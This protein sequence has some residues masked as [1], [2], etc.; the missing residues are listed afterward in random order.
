[1]TVLKTFYPFNKNRAF[2]QIM[3]NRSSQSQDEVSGTTSDNDDNGSEDLGKTVVDPCTDSEHIECCSN[4]KHSLNEPVK[5]TDKLFTELYPT[6]G[7]NFISHEAKLLLIEQANTT[8]S[9]QDSQDDQSNQEYQRLEDDNYFCVEFNGKMYEAKVLQTGKDD[10]IYWKRFQY[11]DGSEETIFGP[12]L[13][14]RVRPIQ[15]RCT[16]L[17]RKEKAVAGHR[18]CSYCKQSDSNVLGPFNKVGTQKEV[19]THATCSYWAPDLVDFI[20]MDLIPPPPKFAAKLFRSINR[21]ARLKCVLCDK[22]GAAVGCCLK[23]CK[24]TYHV[25]CALKD[26]ANFVEVKYCFYG[27]RIIE[28]LYTIYCRDCS[29]FSENRSSSPSNP[30]ELRACMGQLSTREKQS[31][32]SSFWMIDKIISSRRK[33]SI[34][35]FKISFLETTGFAWLSEDNIFPVSLLREYKESKKTQLFRNK[36]NCSSDDSESS[37]DHLDDIKEDIIL[38]DIC[39]GKDSKKKNP[40]LLCDGKGCSVAVHK[41]C[42]WIEKIPDDEW[43]CD[44]CAA[45]VSVTLS[46]VYCSSNNP[47]Q[48]MLCE[49]GKWIHATC[50][51]DKEKPQ[52]KRSPGRLDSPSKKLQKSFASSKKK[53]QMA[54][55]SSRDRSDVWEIIF[56]DVITAK[57]PICRVNE[58]SKFGSFHCAHIDAS[59][60]GLGAT[61]QDEIYNM[62]PS[63]AHCN[64]QCRTDCLI[65]FM[66]KSLVM[67]SHIKPLLFLKIKS[68]L[69]SQAL[70]SPLDYRSLHLYQDF[71]SLVGEVYHPKTIDLLDSLLMLT[72][73]EHHNLFL[74]KAFPPNEFYQ[75]FQRP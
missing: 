60:K 1:M 68:I 63:C 44:R 71:S 4:Q 24:H 36:Q 17:H 7:A 46:C 37:N 13:T 31:V 35:E 72:P 10:G 52:R 48:A 39:K 70:T 12:E 55:L 53:L 61:A 42:Y 3:G 43:K 5:D 40:I 74:S 50:K 15:R 56:R 51:V 64:A 30:I 69:A 20:C 34:E 29:I 6:V 23:A 16:D 62:V 54:R 32:A 67:R 75:F 26:G 25:D 19:F 14:T 47:S 59:I 57:C 58:I 18:T 65:D 66:A 22:T 9:S 27:H 45:R 33:S 73:E 11:S 21:S 49:N 2:L 41:I 8:S 28:R 38:C